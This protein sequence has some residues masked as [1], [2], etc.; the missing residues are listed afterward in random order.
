MDEHQK[1]MLVRQNLQLQKYL[2]KAMEY[3]EKE[4]IKVAPLSR[5]VF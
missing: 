5:T 3:E 2:S 1:K 4:R